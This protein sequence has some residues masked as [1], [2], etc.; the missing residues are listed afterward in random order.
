[1]PDSPAVLVIDADEDTIR[2]VS[3]VCVDGD[4]FVKRG[5]P[6]AD[7]VIVTAY[8]LM[9]ALRENGVGSARIV[10]VDQTVNLTNLELLQ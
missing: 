1:M 10:V 7:E 2:G 9:L 8:I 4:T 3:C 5:G 6:P